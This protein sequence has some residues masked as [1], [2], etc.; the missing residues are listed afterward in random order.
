MD[1][2]RFPFYVAFAV[3]YGTH[4][5]ISLSCVINACALKTLKRARATVVKLDLC[6]HVFR[7]IIID[8]IMIQTTAYDSKHVTLP[9]RAFLGD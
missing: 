3:V 7:R 9:V 1:W 4:A 5:G 2:V 8:T 6:R